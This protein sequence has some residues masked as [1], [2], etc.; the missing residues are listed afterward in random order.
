VFI[1]AFFYCKTGIYKSILDGR[2]TVLDGIE[3][4]ARMNI[5][6]INP[7]L[8]MKDVITPSNLSNPYPSSYECY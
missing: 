1:S 2:C 4:K 7:V 8:L 6:Q 5:L 3:S